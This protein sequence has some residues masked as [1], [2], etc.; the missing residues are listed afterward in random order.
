MGFMAEHFGNV[1]R[2]GEGELIIKRP[3]HLFV[4]YNHLVEEILKLGSKR[5]PTQDSSRKTSKETTKAMAK[6][7][8]VPKPL[9]LSV[10]E[11]LAQALEHKT[12]SEDRLDSLRSEAVVLNDAVMNTFRSRPEVVPDDRGRILPLLNDKYLSRAFF[13][14]MINAVKNWATWDYIVRLLR[15]L[16]GMHEN[17]KRSLLIQELSNTSTWGIDEHR[18]TSGGRCR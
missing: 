14:T 18:R 4:F 11:V 6:L 10:S 17:V 5:R 13:E 1:F 9:K 8:I 12:A 7:A 16:D 15:M 2:A 3:T